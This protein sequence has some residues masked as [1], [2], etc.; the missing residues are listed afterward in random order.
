MSACPEQQNPGRTHP[1]PMAPCN[2]SAASLPMWRA[3]SWKAPQVVCYSQGQDCR[4]TGRSEATEEQKRKTPDQQ[5]TGISKWWKARSVPLSPHPLQHV[6]SPD[7]LILVILI[8]VRW[9]LRFVLIHTSLIT[10]VFEY[11][12]RHFSDIWDSSVVKSRFS[13]ILHFFFFDWVVCLFLWLTSWVLSI[14]WILTFYWMW[15]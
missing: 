4:P 11:F 8:G 13:S 12:F 7:T 9:N 1:T 3:P 14:F 6:L 5:T 10:K 15:G 2:I